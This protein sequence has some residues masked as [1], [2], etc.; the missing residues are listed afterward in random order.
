[1]V[2]RTFCGLIRSVTCTRASIAAREVTIVAQPRCSR[3]RSS[4]SSG[5]TSQN[6]SGWS[7]DRYG[8]VR[9][10]PPAVWCSV[11]RYVVM[12]K[13]K[14]FDWDGF[15][16]STSSGEPS[17]AGVGARRVERVQD[18]RLLRLVVR[19]ERAVGQAVRREQPRLAVGLHDERLVA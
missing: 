4:A 6:S 3:P 17:P 8:T 13:G 14:R 1:M 9:L 2:P 7:S 12:A 15:F 5:L 16:G 10:I 18:G 11:S 19:R